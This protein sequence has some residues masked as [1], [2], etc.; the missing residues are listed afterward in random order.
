M[1]VWTFE[2]EHHRLEFGERII[3]IHFLATLCLFHPPCVKAQANIE[4]GRVRHNGIVEVRNHENIPCIWT[5][6]IA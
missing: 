2:A 4:R 3:G 1:V 5:L 6:A